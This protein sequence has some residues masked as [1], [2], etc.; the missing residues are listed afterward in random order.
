MFARVMKSPCTNRPLQHEVPEIVMPRNREGT[1]YI[2]PE[3]PFKIF[4]DD[5]GTV[6][7]LCTHTYVFSEDADYF[8]VAF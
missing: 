7:R 8:A 6:S 4:V 5:N 1:N 3:R 2:A